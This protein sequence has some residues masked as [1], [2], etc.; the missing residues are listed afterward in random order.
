MTHPIDLVLAGETETLGS[1]YWVSFDKA[2]M[3]ICSE[4]VVLKI[5]GWNQSKGIRREI[6]YFKKQ[7]KPVHFMRPSEFLN[8]SGRSRFLKD[9]KVKKR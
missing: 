1:N 9:R 6:E 8:S 4:M 3:D 2:F 5:K 7:G